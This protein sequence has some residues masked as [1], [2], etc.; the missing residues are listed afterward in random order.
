MQNLSAVFFD[1][2]GVLCTDRFYTTL[3]PEYPQVV[4]WIGRN[5]FGAEKYCDSWMRGELTWWEINKV[6]AAATGIDCELLDDKLAES[7][8]LMQVNPALLRFAENLKQ[9]G[10]KIALVTGNMDIFNEITVPEKGLD[11][12]FPLIVNSFDYR[13]M[14][15]DEDGKLFDI[16]LKKLGLNS[17]ENVWLIDDSAT[18]CDIFRAKGG[19]AHQYS[20]QNDFEKWAK[21]ILN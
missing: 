8:R 3:L 18:Y 14:K 11:R 16:A 19:N 6:I 5:I 7:V 4:R 15:Q 21:E 13:M 12:V 20:N 1:F 2:D 17:Y 10:V 9:K